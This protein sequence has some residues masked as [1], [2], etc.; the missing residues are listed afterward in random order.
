[1]L[2]SSGAALIGAEHLPVGAA[3]AAGMKPQARSRTKSGA[4]Y[5]Q[6]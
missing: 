4:I 1:M 6:R 2:A 5:P 3:S